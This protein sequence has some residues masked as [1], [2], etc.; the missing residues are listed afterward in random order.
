[1]LQF[2]IEDHRVLQFRIEGHRVLQFK[3]PCGLPL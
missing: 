1:V 3:A 2:R